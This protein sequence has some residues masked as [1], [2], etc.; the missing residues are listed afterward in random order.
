MVGTG[1]SYIDQ[2]CLNTTFSS[3]C[4]IAKIRRR[5]YTKLSIFKFLSLFTSKIT[6]LISKQGSRKY[7]GK[8]GCSNPV[9]IVPILLS[10]CNKTW[11]VKR[12]G[13]YKSRWRRALSFAKSAQ[14]HCVKSQSWDKVTILASTML[15]L[16]K[17]TPTHN[18]Q[19]W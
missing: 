18:V 16:R 9:I 12:T 2:F 13:I 15:S 7:K 11:C 5:F 4:I 1:T 8:T 19:I 3:N 10:K 6:F 14:G 17:T